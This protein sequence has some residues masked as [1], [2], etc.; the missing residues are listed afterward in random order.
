VQVGVNGFHVPSRDP[1]ALAERIYALL[2]DSHC[3]EEMGR[4]ARRDA[5]E[6]AWPNIADR[7]VHVYEDLF[8]HNEPH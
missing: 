1:E 6:Y 5:Q 8:D 3:R 4:Q 7:I 2:T